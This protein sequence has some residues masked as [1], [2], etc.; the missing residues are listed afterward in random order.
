MDSK[1]E[2]DKK[3][4]NDKVLF[5]FKI[6]SYTLTPVMEELEALLVL[7]HLLKPKEAR[8]LIAAAGSASLAL[9]LSHP[10]LENW[11]TNCDWKE[12]LELVES[13]GVKLLSFLDPKYPS[14]L[15]ELSDPPPLLYIKGELA[16]TDHH[17]LGIVG[18]RICSLYGKEM[19]Y[20]LAEE[21]ARM[22]LTI[23][24]GLARGIDTAAHQGALSSGRTVAFIGSGLANL[25]PRDNLKLA[26]QISEHGAVISELPMKTAPAKH[27]FPRRNRLIAAFSDGVL[28][29]E[30][31]IKSGAMITMHN[32]ESL[33]KRCFA[34]PGRADVESFRGNHLLIKNQ[35][36]LLVENGQEMVSLLQP[37]KGKFSFQPKK[38]FAFLEKDEQSILALFPSEEISFEELAAKIEL[39]TAKLSAKLM[40]LILKGAIRELPGKY[41]KKN[42]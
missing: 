36:A 19:T 29:A 24:S 22:G 17:G 20:K 6:F 31:P 21:V 34:L 38:S 4:T 1:K 5:F 35:K 3:D 9:K 26:D 23:V 12:D 8:K 37:D 32:A 16:E 18:T 28:L 30:A 25:Y 7:S 10:N 15:H 2:K 33:G 42:D 40:S 39:P 11:E 27:L 14:S 13:E 41:Y